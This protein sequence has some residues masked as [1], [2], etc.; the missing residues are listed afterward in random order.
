MYL[1]VAFN[2]LLDLFMGCTSGAVR[3]ADRGRNTKMLHFRTLD[4]GMD[5]LR[6]VIVQLDFIERPGG[7]VIV[8]L[9]GVHAS[10]LEQPP[11]LETFL[12]AI[13]VEISSDAQNLHFSSDKT[14]CQFVM[15]ATSITYIGYVGVLTGVRKGLSMS[16]NFRPTHNQS[17]RFSNFRFYSH[18]LLVLLGFR[19]SISSLLRGY[20]LSNLSSKTSHISVPALE[21]IQRRLP[22]VT[23]TAAYLIF[24]DGNNALTVEKDHR[25]ALIRSAAD[26]IVATNHDVAEENATH[27]SKSTHEDSFQTLL[28]GIV[29]ES[30]SRRVAMVNLWEKS[31]REAKS[32]SSKNGGNPTQ[33]SVIG[34]MNADPILNEETHFATVMDPKDGKLLW[35]KRYLEPFEWK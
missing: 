13:Y 17:R 32:N 25:D 27:N 29:I 12:E 21:N 7:Q 14:D 22:K 28:G 31:L 26:F 15:Q 9:F 4:W 10:A 16:L 8:R 19:P 23:T 33:D 6:K 20:L 24:S 5:A 1:L 18:H 34:W 3:V 35:T 30:V 11:S 2:V